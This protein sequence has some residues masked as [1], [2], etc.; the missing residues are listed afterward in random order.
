MSF[1]DYHFITTWKI[2]GPIEKA[3]Q[4]LSDGKNYASWWQPAYLSTKEIAPRK[5]EALVRAKLPY[6]LRFVT[7]LERENPPHEFKIRAS[8]E[9]EGT[10]LWRLKQSGDITEIKFFWD[11]RAN[12]PFVRW[13]S[14]LLKP[15]FEWNHDWVM[16]TGEAAL[17]TE[18]DRL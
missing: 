14:C 1:S 12:K 8:G 4:V 7:E 9:L 6:N 17:Q 2:R 15:L 16:K 18:V 11:V 10:G 5:I 13:F 3:Y